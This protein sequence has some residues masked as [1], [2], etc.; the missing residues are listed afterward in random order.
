MFLINSR[1][2]LIFETPQRSIRKAL[3][4]KGCT[5]SRSYGANLPS[6]FTRVISHALVFSTCPPVSV[7]GTVIFTHNLEAFLG[8][9]ASM[10]STHTGL[11]IR[12][13]INSHPDFPK[14]PTY[15]VKLALPT[16]SSPSL[17]RHPFECKNSTGI[18]ACFP[19]T[20]P[21]GLALGADSPYA[22]ER[23]V[24]NLGLPAGRSLTC[25]IVTHVSIRTSDTS[26]PLSKEPSSAYRTLFY[27]HCLRN[28]P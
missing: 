22:D 25:L 20:T 16:A 14:Q 26:S 23:C 11:L 10:T 18:F 9:L 6:S 8:S 21:L 27:H 7:C 13:Q 28:N 3:H 4:A 17:L 2:H 19:S 1:D 5:F 12:S 24:G 15:S